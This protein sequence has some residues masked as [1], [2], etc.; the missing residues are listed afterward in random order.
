MMAFLRMV[1]SAED[2]EAMLV[3]CQSAAAAERDIH[4]PLNPVPALDVEM[5]PGQRNSGNW[6]DF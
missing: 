6:L 2:P 5:N 3:G 1:G 4:G